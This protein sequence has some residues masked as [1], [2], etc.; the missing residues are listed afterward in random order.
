MWG[1]PQ[2]SMMISAGLSRPPTTH[3]TC[4]TEVNVSDRAAPKI[5]QS[6]ATQMQSKPRPDTQLGT[7]LSQCPP[8]LFMAD[9]RAAQTACP[10][11]PARQLPS[12]QCS[13]GRPRTWRTQRKQFRQPVPLS[14][15]LSRPHNK[16]WLLFAWLPSLRNGNIIAAAEGSTDVGSWSDD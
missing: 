12:E 2:R 1:I 13:A 8:L 10:D 14:K 9:D 16:D 15:H 11:Q 6:M 7:E 4:R 5:V 3:E